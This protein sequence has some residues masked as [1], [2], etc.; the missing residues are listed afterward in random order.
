MGPTA[1]QQNP[2]A[3]DSGLAVTEGQ[4]EINV[5]AITIVIGLASNCIAFAGG[6]QQG[7]PQEIGIALP[8]AQR[9]KEDPSLV[10]PAWMTR[11]RR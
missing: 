3:P 9:R 5:V 2:G 4:S 11:I 6:L 10:P 7:G 8:Q 1:A